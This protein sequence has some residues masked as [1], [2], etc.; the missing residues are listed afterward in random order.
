MSGMLGGNK[1]VFSGVGEI[2]SYLRV[3]EAVL[4][5]W[6]VNGSVNIKKLGRSYTA[7]REQLQDIIRNGVD[8]SE[9]PAPVEVYN[10]TGKLLGTTTELILRNEP[11]MPEY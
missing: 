9:A 3:S 6:L 2:A 1:E 7:T 11:H 8:E 10:K 4:S 5:R